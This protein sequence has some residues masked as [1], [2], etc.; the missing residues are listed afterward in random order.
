MAFNSALPVQRNQLINPIAATAPIGPD[1]SAASRT[2]KGMA[3]TATRI[4][5][6]LTS[7]EEK[8]AAQQLA[9]AERKAR[10]AEQNALPVWHTNSTVS[11]EVTAL[12]S[13]EEAAR[14]ERDQLLAVQAEEEEEKKASEAAEMTDEVAQYYAQLARDQQKA[15]QEAAESDE[16][17][18][19]D[20]DD[21][22]EEEGVFE[23]V[24]VVA[25]PEEA[26]GRSL[27]ETVQLSSSARAEPMSRV[28]SSESGSGTSVS[29]PTAAGTAR[30]TPLPRPPPSIL[31]N[32]TDNAEDRPSPGKRRKVD[33][34]SALSTTT[35][36]AEN[37]TTTK[38]ATKTTTTATKSGLGTNAAITTTATTTTTI[39]ASE[40]IE[41]KDDGNNEE[42][43]EVE[44][45]DV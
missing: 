13:R 21:D 43:D 40:T 1:A 16:E 23:D 24:A 36:L 28:E 31:P 7:N 3:Q 15:Q 41:I 6:D 2:V 14:R 17:E 8:S 12:G 42:E 27:P 38:S 19:D 9:E 30:S 5:V 33:D 35:S 4:E 26:T 22:D 45:E 11:G 39:S 37:G 34:T 32:N 25:A 18:E 44:F 29:N 20:D 10:L